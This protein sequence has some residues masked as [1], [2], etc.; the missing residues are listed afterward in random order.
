V[1][2]DNIVGRGNDSLDNVLMDE[3]IILFPEADSAE[4]RG[5]RFSI[6]QVPIFDAGFGTYCFKIIGHGATFCTV[7]DCTINHKGAG[8]FMAVSSGNVFVSKKT[9]GLAFVK[10][11]VEG[12]LIHLLLMTGNSNSCLLRTGLPTL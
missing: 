3:P 2:S 7:Q 10:P 9:A 6:F 11:M 12:H 8:T 4:L 5:K 1:S